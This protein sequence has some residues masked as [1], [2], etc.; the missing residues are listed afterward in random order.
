MLCWLL[1]D[2]FL[3]PNPLLY[4]YS[5]ALELR[6]AK[7]YFSFH[8]Y[9]VLEE[10]GRQ[11]EGDSTLLLFLSES[12]TSSLWQ[13]SD[14]SHSCAFPALDSLPCPLVEAMSQGYTRQRLD[15]GPAQTRNNKGQSNNQV[16]RIASAVRQVTRATP[17]GHMIEQTSAN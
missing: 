9:G 5:T 8:Q 14:R 13:Q 12:F 7:N 10:T 15:T 16:C 3:A 17:K 6:Q 4:I 2:C 1:S 11:E